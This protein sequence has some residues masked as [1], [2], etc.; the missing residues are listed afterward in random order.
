MAR[1][2]VPA[3]V[4]IAASAS[5]PGCYGGCYDEAG[6]VSTLPQTS[7]LTLFGGQSATDSTVCAVPELGGQNGC[8]SALTLPATYAG[9]QP[10]VFPPGSTIVYPLP[11]GSVASGIT[12]T[13]RGGGVRDFITVGMLG[14]D[15]V[16]ITF[17]V[18][19][20]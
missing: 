15:S 8:D 12:V 2:A 1:F 5:M 10:Y 11:V 6:P 9:G 4:L 18:R 3:L 17:T 16:T 19:D 20:K 7:C 13:D 14:A